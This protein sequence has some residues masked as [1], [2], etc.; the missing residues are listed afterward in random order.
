MVAPPNTLLNRL[1][2]VKPALQREYPLRRL[3][4]FGSQARGQATPDSDID[5]LVDVDPSIGLRF[6]ELA[7]RLESLLGR[8]V[9]LVSTRAL[10]PALRARIEVDT[11]E[12]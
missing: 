10:K 6:C 5:L 2:E 3:A 11:I 8:P 1:R 9:D 12:I 4:L 7:D